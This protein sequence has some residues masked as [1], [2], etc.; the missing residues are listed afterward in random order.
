MQSYSSA[1]DEFQDFET[2][3]IYLDANENPNQNGRSEGG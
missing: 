3:M 2:K 1:R